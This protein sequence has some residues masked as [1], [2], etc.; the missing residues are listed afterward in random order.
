MLLMGTVW[1]VC[2]TASVFAQQSKFSREQLLSA[3][4]EIMITTRYCALITT[5]QR[6]GVNA[7]T[8]DAFEPE[9]DMTVWFGT[10][11]LS[12]KVLEIRRHPRV[13]LYY[14]DR[15]NQAYV[16]IRGIARIVNDTEAKQRHWKEDWKSFYPD[17]DQSYMLIRVQPLRLEVVNVKAGIVGS[18]RDWQ[19]PSVIFPAITR[20]AK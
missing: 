12:R 4:R 16:T 5:G 20:R 3:A 8:M 14:F 18:G 1:L 6:G 7:R 15:E 19:P 13:T 17:R 9:T 11:P 2:A 10:N